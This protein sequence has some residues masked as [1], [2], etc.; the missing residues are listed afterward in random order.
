MKF[1]NTVVEIQEK[2]V[3]LGYDLPEFGADGLYGPETLSAVNS[4]RKDNGLQPVKTLNFQDTESLLSK[5]MD[6]R[7]Q[8]SLEN[9]GTEL[10]MAASGADRELNNIWGNLYGALE[11]IRDLFSGAAN[12]RVSEE[13]TEPETHQNYKIV[14]DPGHGDNFGYGVDPGAVRTLADGTEVYE[15]DIALGVSQHLEQIL[16]ERGYEVAMTRNGDVNVGRGNRF[17]IRDDAIESENPDLF[18]SI[19]ANALEQQVN[20]RVRGAEVHI[21]N[22]GSRDF[23][24]YLVGEFNSDKVK[25]NDF[26]VLT[27][28]ERKGATSALFE[29]GFM[30]NPDELEL[31]ASEE[32]QRQYAEKLADAI[33][34]Y[35]EAQRAQ[36]YDI[37]Q[38]TSRTGGR[39]RT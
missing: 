39:G 25:T 8:Q 16:A 21:A 37:A 33:I 15:K 19:H 35:S 24:E 20:T 3:S 34:S 30:S 1:S 9:R 32:G 28:G 22:E 17:K 7:F 6:E 36:H 10:I 27:E 11:A 14:I 29:L 12:E 2:L 31:M 38:E 4:F 23:A 18:L 13:T 5:T 26:H